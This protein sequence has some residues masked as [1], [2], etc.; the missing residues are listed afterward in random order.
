MLESNV[1]KLVAMMSSVFWDAT[2][3][4][5]QPTFRRMYILHNYVR[6]VN[7]NTAEA[8]GEP[9]K[10]ITKYI[11]VNR[12]DGRLEGNIGEQTV[13]GSVTLEVGCHFVLQVYAVIYLLFSFICVC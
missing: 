8:G 1:L 12:M 4:S 9:M 2:S 6:I 7:Q 5:S 10:A 11:S 3:G 13:V